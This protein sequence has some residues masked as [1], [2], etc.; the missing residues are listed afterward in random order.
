MDTVINSTPN[1]NISKKHENRLFLIKLKMFYFW[2]L[3]FPRV[4]K[5]NTQGVKSEFRKHLGKK[6]GF[7][8]KA[9]TVY[10]M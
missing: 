5:H 7:D 8:A 6:S 9:V 4:L 3:S 2:A 10:R 1:A